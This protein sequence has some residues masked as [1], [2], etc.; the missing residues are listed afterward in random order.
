MDTANEAEVRGFGQRWAILGGGG[1]AEEPTRGGMTLQQISPRVHVP[2]G[3][4][5]LQVANMIQTW[6]VDEVLALGGNS[7]HKSFT[8]AVQC[9]RQFLSNISAA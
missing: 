8:P 4:A 9:H 7:T 5:C 1:V 3:V 2:P 6:N